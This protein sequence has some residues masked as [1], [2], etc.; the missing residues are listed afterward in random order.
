MP[1]HASPALAQ[2][3]Q[4][5]NKCMCEQAAVAAAAGYVIACALMRM[6]GSRGMNIRR[7]VRYFAEARAPGIYKDHYI[8][9]LFKWVGEGEGGLGPGGGGGA[10]GN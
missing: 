5:Y 9:D 1:E 10:A 3:Q 6:Y 4:A 2:H 7:A 8:T